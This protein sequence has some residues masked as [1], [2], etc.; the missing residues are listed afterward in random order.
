MIKMKRLIIVFL[1]FFSCVCF[2]QEKSQAIGLRLGMVQGITY[3]NT[4]N[5][6]FSGEAV[7]A[8]FRYNPMLLGFVQY[9]VPKFL[10]NEQMA[11]FFGLGI[12]AAYIEGHKNV[13]WYPD[14]QSQQLWHFL[15]GVDAQMGI[16]YNFSE[17][18]LNLSLDFRP[19]YNLVGHNGYWFDMAL[20]IRY[21]LK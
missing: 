5:E 9:Y 2:A 8:M 20:S 14:F 1:C 3:Q 15:S 18:P 13:E 17:F 16:K 12:H 11:L 10:D 19:A 21:V 7:L 4:I 6:S